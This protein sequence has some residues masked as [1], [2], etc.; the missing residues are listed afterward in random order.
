M[1][2]FSFDDNNTNYNFGSSNT[3]ECIKC[4][5]GPKLLRCG[6]CNEVITINDLITYI[7][8]TYGQIIKL[9]RYNGTACI[10]INVKNIY[11][12]T[13]FMKSNDVATVAVN[14]K[15]ETNLIQN[16]SQDGSVMS[17][18]KSINFIELTPNFVNNNI[19]IK[20]LVMCSNMDA[21]A[22]VLIPVN[23]V[24]VETGNL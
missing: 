2:F 1:A 12:I 15:Y 19:D 21:N 11:N 8:K 4:I 24:N 9:V 17:G 20:Y 18:I 10:R 5:D 13:K 16:K 3:I 22:E 23:M 14:F 7:N 6:C